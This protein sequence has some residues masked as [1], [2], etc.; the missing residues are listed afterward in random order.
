MALVQCERRKRQFWKPEDFDKKPAAA[1]EYA[2]KRKPS[3]V[4]DVLG[5]ASVF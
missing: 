3:D 5:V 4:C 1:V 2:R